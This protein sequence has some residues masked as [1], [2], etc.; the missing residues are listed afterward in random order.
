[1]HPVTSELDLAIREYE[2][3]IE[4]RAV[5]RQSLARDAARHSGQVGPI[6]RLV[7]AARR[8]LDPR[9]YALDQ[10][11]RIDAP[12]SRTAKQAGT[13]PVTTFPEPAGTTMR[14]A[15]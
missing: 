7:Q 9:G 3:Q 12:A 13:T 4:A 11:G 1:M 2:R 15:A 10:A 14:K 8:F 5:Q 6:V